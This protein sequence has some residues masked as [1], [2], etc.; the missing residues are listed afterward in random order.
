M[1][2]L[3]YKIM[4]CRLPNNLAVRVCKKSNLTSTMLCKAESHPR[5]LKPPGDDSMLE[6][7]SSKK[8]PARPR[9]FEAEHK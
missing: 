3:R 6:M 4:E 7:T 1:L 9:M 8:A 2:V 5:S